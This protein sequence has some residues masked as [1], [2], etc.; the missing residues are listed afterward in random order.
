MENNKFS[1]IFNKDQYYKQYAKTMSPAPHISVRNNLIENTHEEK[2][3]GGRRAR[4]SR[5]G[6]ARGSR[7]GVLK[8]QRM[9][10]RLALNELSDDFQNRHPSDEVKGRTIP[11]DPNQLNI[12]PKTQNWK[13]KG[14]DGRQNILSGGIKNNRPNIRP[15]SLNYYNVQGRNPQNGNTYH[16]RN[17]AAA[18]P[19]SSELMYP[20]SRGSFEE[21]KSENYYNMNNCA[22]PFHPSQ[23]MRYHSEINTEKRTPARRVYPDTNGGRNQYATGYYGQNEVKRQR[24]FMEKPVPHPSKS[25]HQMAGAFQGAPALNGNAVEFSGYLAAHGNSFPVISNKIPYDTFVPSGVPIAEYVPPARAKAHQIGA[26][27]RVNNCHS[28]GTGLEVG[29]ERRRAPSRGRYGSTAHTAADDVPSPKQ[30]FFDIS[31]RSFLIG[32]RKKSQA[33]FFN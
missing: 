29:A 1:D 24:N 21:N 5:G 10:L 33:H 14:S 22:R 26:Y 32:G 9:L 25:Y 4:G 20:M 2:R 13:Q 8:R 28:A 19:P 17:T 12:L 27:Q 11:M 3:R 23:H 18:D 31:P 15:V 7:G 6:G 30:S 16:S